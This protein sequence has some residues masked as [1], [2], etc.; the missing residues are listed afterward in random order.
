MA[1]KT[2]HPYGF[3]SIEEHNRAYKLF[4]VVVSIAMILIIGL[5]ATTV[6]CDIKGYYYEY[7]QFAYKNFNY[8]LKPDVSD[9]GF[10]FLEILFNKI[11]F[12]FQG[13]NIVYAIFNISVISYLIYKKS[14]LPLL[15]YILY[16]CFDFFVLDLTMIRQTTA[17]SVIILAVLSDENDGL[18][19]IIKFEIIVIIAYFIHA[20][21]IMFS[22]MFILRRLK[23]TKKK[24]FI[25]LGTAL[26]VFILKPIFIKLVFF[27]AGNIS[28][29]YDALY[30]IESGNA[31]YKLYFMIIASVLLGL[32]LKDFLNDKWNQLMF[33]YM[34]MMLIIFPTVQGGGALMR[35]YFY[36]YIFMIVYVP[37]MISGVNKNSDKFTYYMAIFLYII[38]GCSQLYNIVANN[39]YLVLPYKFFWQ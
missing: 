18:R 33:Y 1:V 25:F 27:V 7:N 31:G 29:K 6:G 10:S 22:P 39:T 30:S 17:M 28:D 35:A 8:L 21:A 11:G 3:D 36:F 23:F 14:S 5:K 9:K 16:I 4:F 2:Y 26:V 20:S 19:S 13:F 34:C 37:N 38:V 12:S 32:Y 15:S 24:V